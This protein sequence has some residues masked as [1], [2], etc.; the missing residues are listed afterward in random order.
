[1]LAGP[2]RSVTAATPA[3]EHQ[4]WLRYLGFYTG[5]RVNELC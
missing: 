3:L 2:E 5:A 4:F 1:M